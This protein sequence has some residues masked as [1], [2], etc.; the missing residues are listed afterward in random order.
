[1]NCIRVAENCTSLRLGY[2][3]WAIS[4]LQPRS[5]LP[6]GWAGSLM[7][8][9]KVPFDQHSRRPPETFCGSCRSAVYKQDSSQ[10]QGESDSE[11]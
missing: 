6:C 1:M 2:L 4:P 3:S 11:S 7:V 8:V 9:L 10:L 5:L